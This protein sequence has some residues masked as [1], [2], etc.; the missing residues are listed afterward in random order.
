RISEIDRDYYLIV[1]RLNPYKRVDLAIEAFNELG[2]P[3]RIIGRGPDRGRLQKLAGPNVS[4]LGGQTDE[5]IAGQLAECR[6]L[7][8]PGEEDFGIAP[9]EAMAAGRPVIAFRAGGAVET[10]VEGETGVF[11]DE[12]TP[13]ALVRAVNRSKFELFDKQRIR[14]QALKYD[15]SVFK[16]KME[17]F[18]KEKYEEKSS[19]S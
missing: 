10:V 17:D 11:F 16:K 8:F 6:A 15:K 12:Q 19:G 14:R 18:I 5:Q 4:F 9:V 13:A 7:V 3:L 1:S 2:L